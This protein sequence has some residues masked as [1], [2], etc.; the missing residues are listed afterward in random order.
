[1]EIKTDAVD[2]TVCIDRSGSMQKMYEETISGLNKFIEEQKNTA[3][4]T[5]IPTNITLKTFDDICSII[6]GFD[7]CPIKNVPTIDCKYLQIGRA[8]V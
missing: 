7:N 4:E 6:P 2:I 5:N 8:H 1:M 3:N